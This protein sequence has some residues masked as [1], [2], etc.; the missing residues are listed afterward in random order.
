MSNIFN[1]MKDVY[2]LQKQ[3]RQ[4]RKELRKQEIVGISK[5][6]KVKIYM[7]GAQEYKDI[8]IDDSL[9]DP[10]LKDLLKKDI[11]QAFSDFQSKLQKNLKKDMDMD[12]IKGML[13]Q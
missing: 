4:M 13:G 6:E 10:N 9:M 1:N 8:E 2:K 7:N 5:D 3:A 12:D 11:E